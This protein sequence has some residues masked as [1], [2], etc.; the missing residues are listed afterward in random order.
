MLITEEK[1]GSIRSRKEEYEIGEL[2][3][4]VVAGPVV[5]F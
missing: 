3:K 5:A 2:C 4:K 1:D